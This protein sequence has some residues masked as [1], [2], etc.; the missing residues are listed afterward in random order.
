VAV[1][2]SED[3]LEDILNN[4][5]QQSIEEEPVDLNYE[6]IPNCVESLLLSDSNQ[7]MPIITCHNQPHQQSLYMKVHRSHLFP[8]VY[9][10]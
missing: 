3:N 6:D 1:A 10:L 7:T 2:D 4:I 9:Y 5:Q 8:V